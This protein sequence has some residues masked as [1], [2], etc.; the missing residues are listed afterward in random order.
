MSSHPVPTNS[1]QTDIEPR[2]LG[3]RITACEAMGQKGLAQKQKC[4]T[5]E[6]CRGSIVRS[7]T[8]PEVASRPT[9]QTRTQAESLA[10]RADSFRSL[11]IDSQRFKTSHPSSVDRRELR[12]DV[13]ALQLPSMLKRLVPV[14]SYSIWALV[15]DFRGSNILPCCYPSAISISFL[16]QFVIIPSFDIE[17]FHD[18]P[19]TAEAPAI[20][21]EFASLSTED[22]DSE[23]DGSQQDAVDRGV[24]EGG[25]LN[26]DGGQVKGG[27][28]YIGEGDTFYDDGDS[29][30]G[31]SQ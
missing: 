6:K 29:G 31:E 19:N 13:P 16:N 20:N 7:R 15:L 30:G 8:V 12:R 22:N 25:G 10:R 26:G 21:S 24:N 17:Y 14:A 28:G 2:V 23:D 5:R 9:W 27:N 18:V 4:R 3:D 11:S 1:S